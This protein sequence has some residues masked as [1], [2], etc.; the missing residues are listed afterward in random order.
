MN[1]GED[2]LP[3]IARGAALLDKAQGTTEWYKLINLDEFDMILV[4]TCVLGQLYGSYDA[5][6]KALGITHEQAVEWGFALSKPGAYPA[7]TRAWQN[8]IQSHLDAAHN[9]RHDPT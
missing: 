3:R 2:F 1:T 6:V 8:Y 4:S 5:G 9:I 7:L